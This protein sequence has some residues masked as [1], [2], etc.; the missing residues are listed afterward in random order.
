MSTNAP[1]TFHISLPYSKVVTT[2]T[3]Y[4]WCLPM[5]RTWQLVQSLV[6][7]FLYPALAFPIL[8]EIASS[9]TLSDTVL[10]RCSKVLHYVNSFSLVLVFDWYIPL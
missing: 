4:T 8:K 9:S 3:Q 1:C 10:L 7:N 5:I 2:I 6:F